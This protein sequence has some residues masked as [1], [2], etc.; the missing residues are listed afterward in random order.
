VARASRYLATVN[1]RPVAP[2]ASALAALSR[3]GGPLQEE[4]VDP[5]VVLRLLD[6]YASPATV[7]TAGPRYFGFVT[8]G[9]LPAALGATVLAAAWDQNASLEVMS[10]AAAA[11]ASWATT[12]PDID[13]SVE[14]VA[15]VAKG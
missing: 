6:E 14:A 7:A 11:L 10:P 2:P 9:T 12:E 13:R 1:D 5:A 4:P 15:R 8:G 3:L